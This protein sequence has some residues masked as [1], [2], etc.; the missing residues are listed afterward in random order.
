MTLTTFPVA[1]FPHWS[2]SPRGKRCRGCPSCKP[3]WVLSALY[4]VHRCA[5]AVHEAD[6]VSA[7]AKPTT[8]VGAAHAACRNRAISLEA[9]LRCLLRLADSDSAQFPRRAEV[10][11]T[12]CRCPLRSGCCPSESCGRRRRT[13]NT[14]HSARASSQAH[15]DLRGSCHWRT[16]GSPHP[17]R[18]PDAHVEWRLAELHLRG[19]KRQRLLIWAWCPA[20]WSPCASQSMRRVGN[21]TGA[22]LAMESLQKAAG[23]KLMPIPYMGAAQGITD[24]IGGQ[25]PLYVSSV[26]TLQAHIKSGKMRPAGHHVA[27]AH[28]GPAAGAH[29]GQV[30]LQGLEAITW[31]GSL[32]PAGLCPRTSSPS[33]MPTPTRRCRTRRSSRSSQT[34]EPMCRA[35]APTTLPS[36]F[37]TTS[38]NG[39]SC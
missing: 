31:F 12:R 34:Q 22:Q 13:A 24:L 3:C 19:S 9:R 35:A 30:G 20:H 38:R 5:A 16:S 28:V 10:V 21:G 18:V 39:A 26:P 15:W 11:C 23:V 6:D 8:P 36:S 29:R 1:R 32:G 37:A 25:V 27:A 7:A 2:C 14:R 17:T 33:S 4:C